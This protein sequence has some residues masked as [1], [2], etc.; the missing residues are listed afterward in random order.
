[1]GGI[2]LVNAVLGRVPNCVM[3][4]LLALGHTGNLV[5]SFLDHGGNL[6]GPLSD[7]SWVNRIHTGGQGIS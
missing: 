3:N 5:G 2:S 6:H 7:I 1:M 4:Q